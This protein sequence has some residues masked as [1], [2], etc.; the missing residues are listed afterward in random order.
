MGEVRRQ[1]VERDHASVHR[2][3]PPE[4][5]A[6]HVEQLGAFHLEALQVG[7]RCTP[8]QAAGRE[9]EPGECRN[10]EHTGQG[11]ETQQNTHLIASLAAVA[12][13]GYRGTWASAA[14]GRPGRRGGAASGPRRAPGATGARR[15]PRVRI[16]PRSSRGTSLPHTDSPPSRPCP[17]RTPHDAPLPRVG[18]ATAG[19]GW[20]PLVRFFHHLCPYG[21]RQQTTGR[22]GKT[23]RGLSS[24]THTPASRSGV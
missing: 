6:I 13:L 7:Y 4:G 10:A 20:A 5:L 15:L 12:A 19:G 14:P 9:P 8:T 22:A 11:G 24:P 18:A 23:W 3:Q 16:A 2:R 17:C 1:G 21:N